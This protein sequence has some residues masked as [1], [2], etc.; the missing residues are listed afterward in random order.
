MHSWKKRCGISLGHMFEFYDLAVYGA[1]SAYVSLHFFPHDAFGEQAFY[2][3]WVTFALRF[4]AR[5]IGGLIISSYA[6]RYGRK[7]ILIFTSGLTGIATL[8]MACLPTYEQI[9]LLA[10]ILFCFMQL[11]QAFSVGAELPTASAYLLENASRKEYARIGFLLGGMPFLAVL[12][13]LIVVTSLESFLSVEHMKSFGW[14]IPLLMGIVNIS[15]GYYFKLKIL[16]SSKFIKSNQIGIQRSAA[17]KI[18]FI[19]APT[20]VIFYTNSL[21]SKIIISNFTD[22]PELL[23][24]FSILLNLSYFIVCCICAYCI[25]KWSSCEKALHYT[26]IF[27]ALFGVPIYMLQDLNNIYAIAISQVCIVIFTSLSLLACVPF[28]FNYTKSKNRISTIALGHNVSSV[29]FG[30]FTPLIV[31]YLSQYNQMYIGVFVA[32]SSIFY[33]LALFL[34]KYTH[35]ASASVSTAS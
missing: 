3:V 10:P 29:V 16:E 2:L 32:S 20:S 27:L 9:G 33:F 11:M 18:F 4:L 35:P 31:T 26:Y 6:D 13:S 21:S 28:Y 19:M 23:S 22:S 25:D 12:L 7:P 5:P 24:Y 17:L 15:I 8:I 1:I 34:D 14:R 30:G